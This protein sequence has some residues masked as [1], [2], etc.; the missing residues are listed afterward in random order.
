MSISWAILVEKLIDGEWTF[1]DKYMGDYGSGFFEYI[2]NELG[3]YH[4]PDDICHVIQ[5]Y[6]FDEHE[7]GMSWLYGYGD[8]RKKKYVIKA[9]TITPKLWDK[10]LRDFGEKFTYFPEDLRECISDLDGFPEDYGYYSQ[11][12]DDVRA[13]IMWVC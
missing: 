7:D 2:R 13:T 4:V 11:F 12:N 3:E 9:W 8:K 5:K 6:H 1:I 10:I